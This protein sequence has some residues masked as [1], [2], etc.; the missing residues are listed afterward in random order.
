[1]TAVNN[2]AGNGHVGLAALIEHGAVKKLIC[3]FLRSADSRAFFDRYRAGTI[4]LVPQGTLA[5]RNRA[6]GL[7]AELG[8]FMANIRVT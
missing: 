7:Q 5:E 6:G 3:S 4:E 8:R 2:N 1:M